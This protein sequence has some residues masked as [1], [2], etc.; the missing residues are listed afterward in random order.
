M[1]YYVL[2]VLFP[3]LVWAIYERTSEDKKAM[4]DASIKK[5]RFLWILLASL[6]MFLLIA[7][8]NQTIGPDTGVYRFLFRRAYNKTWSEVFK[9]EKMEFGFL[10]F[11]KIIASFTGDTNVYQIIYTVFYWVTISWFANKLSNNHFVFLVLFG[12]I[13]IYKFMFTGVRQCIAICICIWSYAFIL[14]RKLIPFFIMIIL[15]ATFHKSAGM[16][17]IAYFLYNFKISKK[18]LIIFFAV[19]TVLIL[20]ILPF[21]NYISFFFGYDYEIESTNNGRVSFAVYLI[22]TLYILYVYKSP[23]KK[24]SGS[25]LFGIGLVSMFFWVLRLFTRVAERPTYFFLIFL[26]ASLSENLLNSKEESYKEDRVFLAMVFSM[27]LVLFIYKM[28]TPTY[29]PYSIFNV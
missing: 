2:A 4:K 10:F 7:L 9:T 14:K 24:F 20:L 27:S 5:R 22:V 1:I 26:I 11:E 18:S 16:F 13:G 25:G 15:A 29:V 19:S 6:P 12:T 17:L 21:Q 8:R 28:N 3:I 23:Y